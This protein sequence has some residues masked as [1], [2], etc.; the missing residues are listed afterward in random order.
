MA[1][2]RRTAC[3]ILMNPRKKDRSRGRQ[4]TSIDPKMMLVACRKLASDL[5][6]ESAAGWPPVKLRNGNS[7]SRAD[8]AI[9]MD[10]QGDRWE[11]ETTPLL[12]KANT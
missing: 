9:S 6:A 8:A 1:G 4:R 7:I 11:L 3:D 5:R 12:A 10:Q 2:K